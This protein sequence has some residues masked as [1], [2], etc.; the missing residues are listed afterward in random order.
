MRS[1]ATRYCWLCAAVVGVAVAGCGGAGTPTGPTPAATRTAAAVVATVPVAPTPSSIVSTPTEV[2]FPGPGYE[3][4]STKDYD[5]RLSPGWP[6]PQILFDF[7]VLM[8]GC[9]GAASEVRW[10]SVGG[11]PVEYGTMGP[12]PLGY[13]SLDYYA[14]YNPTSL[15]LETYRAQVAAAATTYAPQG[16]AA[17]GLIRI[18]SACLQPA[19]RVPEG[20][21]GIT[22][23]VA[24]VTFYA[25]VP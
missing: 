1:L 21:N 20:E 12:A 5:L 18:E 7:P 17:E 2:P 6:R 24:R 8:N 14:Q 16:T 4:S 23:I 15:P 3:V 19:F 22:D 11:V 25:A 9:G 10:R 13:A